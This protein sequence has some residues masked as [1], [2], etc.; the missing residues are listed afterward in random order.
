VAPPFPVFSLYSFPE[1]S[2]FPLLSLAESAYTADETQLFFVQ[3]VL[4][5]PFKKALSEECG[6]QY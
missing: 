5:G 6:K 4:N 1:I 3:T 2:F